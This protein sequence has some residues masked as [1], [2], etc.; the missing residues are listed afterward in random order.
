MVTLP[1]PVA[2]QPP[3]VV[4]IQVTMTIEQSEQLLHGIAL[5]LAYATT[6]ERL[7]RGEIDEPPLLVERN[8]QMRH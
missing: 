4:E 7:S 3:K 2:G 6:Q 8:E 1:V 5:V